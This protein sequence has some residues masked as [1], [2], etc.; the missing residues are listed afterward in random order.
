MTDDRR[1]ITI[2]EFCSRAS[3]SRSTLYRL[4]TAG[5]LPRVVRCGK[6]RKGFMLLEVLSWLD[7]RAA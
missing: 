6:R 4:G 5:Q 7:S 2:A 3:I 1:V